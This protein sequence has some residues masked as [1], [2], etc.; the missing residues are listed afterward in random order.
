M[1]LHENW[2]KLK[3]LPILPVAAIKNAW[4]TLRT[5]LVNKWPAA[6]NFVAKYVKTWVKSNV[7]NLS[8]WNC[9]EHT[10]GRRPRTNNV[11]EG[12]NNSIRIAFEVS[13]TIIWTC[14]DC[15]IQIQHKSDSKII[16]Q[17]SGTL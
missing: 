6:S 15:V 7:C 4:K 10:L 14:L 12:G 13:N 1:E 11:F 5:Q 17:D 2:I 8:L 16:Q 9:Y 3:G